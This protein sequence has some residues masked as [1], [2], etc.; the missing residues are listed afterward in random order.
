MP[1]INKSINF[2]ERIGLNRKI[3]MFYEEKNQINLKSD[4]SICKER[5]WDRAVKIFFKEGARMCIA[6]SQK[7]KNIKSTAGIKEWKS[8]R[9]ISES[10]RKLTTWKQ[11]LSW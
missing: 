2:K 8:S 5:K 3:A 6:R 10:K 7:P 9:T 1:I 4:L 11:I